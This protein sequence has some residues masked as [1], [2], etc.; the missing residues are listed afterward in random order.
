M[1][2]IAISV[3]GDRISSR[4]DSSENLMLV[5]VVDGKVKARELFL[6]REKDS[7]KKIEIII[8]LKPE[9]LICGG[10]TN[11]CESK[12]RSSNIKVCSWVQGNAEFILS[13]C[14]RNKFIDGDYNGTS[15]K[16]QYRSQ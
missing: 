16:S 13:L 7:L 3:F 12:L 8:Q 4:L 9:V 11:I 10:L 5:T 15:N 14:L 1:K 6:L 2:T